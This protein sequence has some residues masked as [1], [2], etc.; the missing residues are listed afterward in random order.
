[1]S[2][3][4]EER[5]RQAAI[6]VFSREGFHRA[7]M[8]TIA[9]EAGVAVGTIYNYFP[10]KKDILVSMFETE[11]EERLAF[12]EELGQGGRTIPEQLAALLEQHFSLLRGRTELSRVLLQEQ[13]TPRQ[14]VKERFSAFH[15]RLLERIETL[16]Q[17]G[18]D[19]G[20]VRP[21]NARVIA[22]ALFAV[23]Q[24]VAAFSVFCTEDD[25]D[26]M[27]RVAPGELA[28]FIWKG[29]KK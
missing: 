28:E 29:L 2:H 25:L 19:G 9:R 12:F 18:V 17:A 10:S 20:W 5:I 1:M 27:L 8:E 24:S 21:C 22:L 4:R 11:M 14:D 6:R 26:E 16:I 15:Q 13:F 23:V 3:D 7:R